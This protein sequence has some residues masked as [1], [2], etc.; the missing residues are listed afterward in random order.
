MGR[1][2]L[3]KFRD[4]SEVGFAAVLLTGD[5]RGGLATDEPSAYMLRARQN[6]IFELGYFLSKLGEERVCCLYTSDVEIPS[7]YSGVLYILLDD[8]GAWKQR[9][10]CELR[11][12]GFNVDLNKLL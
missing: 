9:L 1:N 11:D 2:I 3:K 12:A 10:A 7:D 8:A 6:V 4:Y 5:D